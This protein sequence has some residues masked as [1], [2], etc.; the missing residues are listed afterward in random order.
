[1]MKKLLLF[2]AIMLA[3]IA[4]A[5]FSS[6]GILGTATTL[7]WSGTQPDIAMSTTDGIHY[8]LVNIPLYTGGLKFRQDNSWPLNWGSTDWPSGIGVQDQG[9]MDVPVQV[10]VYDISFNLET[11]AYDF[12]YKFPVIGVRGAATSVDWGS[13]DGDIL[14][15]TPDGVTY[16]YHNLSLTTAGL[17]FRQD[18]DWP[19]NW[20]GNGW[21][22]GTGIFN[23]DGVDIQAIEGSYDVTFNRTTLEYDFVQIFP[24][25]GILGS[26][27]TAGWDGPDIDMQTTDGVVYTLDNITLTEGGLKFRLDDQWP[28]NWGGTGW[29]SGTGIFNQNGVDIPCQAG[30][31]NITFN[32]TTLAYSFEEVVAGIESVQALAVSLYPNPASDSIN[33]SFNSTNTFSVAFYDINGRNILSFEAVNPDMDM[34]ISGFAPGVYFARVT[35]PAALYNLQFIKR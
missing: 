12:V 31:Y 14:F 2:F 11:K 19:D 29:P 15:D 30:V 25:V 4:K 34:D 20:G 8:T 32:L 33:F 13:A 26:A 16:S 28:D 21:P 18:N 3:S 17:K 7:G 5:Q 23:Q 27:T 1:M 35:T 6:V 9:G 22:S 24:S 10:G